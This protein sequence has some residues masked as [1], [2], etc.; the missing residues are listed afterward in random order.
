VA[1]PEISVVATKTYTSA[2]AVVALLSTT[3]SEQSPERLDQLRRTADQ[4]ENALSLD[5][6]VKMM[7]ER[8]KDLKECIVIGRG[9]NLCTASEIALNITETSLIGAKSFSAADFQHGPI[10]VVNQGYPVLLIA[11][12]GKG[13]NAM[14][15][16]AE[17]LKA[18]HPALISFAHDPTFL[19]GSE[20]AIRIPGSVPEWLSPLV[21]VVAGQLFAHWL[22]I[23]KGY[24]PDRPRGLTK[25][26]RT[27]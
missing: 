15:S 3:L 23:A 22:A 20:T 14:Q 11:A 21:Y 24:D 9:Y 12:N 27:T 5:N 2:L 18:S 1:G 10:A 19:A 17:K 16:L 6:I 13:F 26:T 25:V 8:Y 7:V 4:I